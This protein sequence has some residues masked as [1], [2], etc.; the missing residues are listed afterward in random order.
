M[1][2]CYFLLLAAQAIKI[3]EGP[4]GKTLTLED[5]ANY[6]NSMKGSVYDGENYGTHEEDR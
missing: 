1:K 4:D 3:Y 2:N 5:C 6:K